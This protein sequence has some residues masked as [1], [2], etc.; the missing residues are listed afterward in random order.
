MSDQEES[1]KDEEVTER[2]DSHLSH[3]ELV[4]M[5][6]T[7]LNTLIK[8]DPLLC[9]LPENVTLD[10]INAQIAVIQG[11]ALT[12]NVRR[13]DGEEV[14]VIVDQRDATVSHLKRAFQ[15]STHL[16]LLRQRGRKV[17]VSWTHIWKTNWLVFA[18]EKLRD[19]NSKLRDLG[20]TNRATVNFA[21]RYRDKLRSKYE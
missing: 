5:T 8:N 6:K 17:A 1:A 21:K 14:K 15:R 9:D 3:E 12:V 2:V 11:T 19:D 7:T 10:E 20:I 13:E 18:G 16:R 4:N